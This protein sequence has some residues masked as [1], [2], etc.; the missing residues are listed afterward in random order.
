MLS[1][2]RYIFG[3]Q[4]AAVISEAEANFSLAKATLTYLCSGIFNEGL[5]AERLRDNVL[6]GKYRLHWFALGQW[7]A[8]VKRCVESSKDRSASHELLELLLRLALERRN[9]NF[10][11]EIEVKDLIFRDI[12]PEWPEL[13]QYIC[14]VLQFR[15]DDKQADWEYS[16]CKLSGA[17]PCQL[18]KLPRTH[19]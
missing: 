7:I 4:T 15:R 12:A 8:L 19:V 3:R 10:H 2:A 5:S 1:R 17:R 13:S 11:G 6:R 18:A 16:N 9:H 14:G